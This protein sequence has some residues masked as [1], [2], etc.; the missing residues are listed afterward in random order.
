MR[1]DGGDAEEEGA[2]GLGRVVEE[3]EGFLSEDVD[4]VL[5]GV[6]DRR[7]AVALEAGVEVHVCVRVQEEVG[8]VP[9][10]GVGGV[11]VVGGVRVEELARVVRVVARLLEPKGEVGVV[12][13][14]TYK[15]GISACS[16]GQRLC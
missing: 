8:A 10:G 15:L 4:R 3:A 9:A 13:P 6:A 16:S 2:G 5:P 7:V 1:G 11:V 14:L 12:K